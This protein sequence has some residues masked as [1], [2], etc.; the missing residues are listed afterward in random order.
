MDFDQLPITSRRALPGAELMKRLHEAYELLELPSRVTPNGRGVEMVN[1]PEED[2]ELA[3][4]ISEIFTR[5][6]EI[7]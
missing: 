1:L 7:E 2:D 6:F 4:L 5:R 3:V